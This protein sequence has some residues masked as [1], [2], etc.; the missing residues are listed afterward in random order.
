MERYKFNMCNR[1]K[2]EAVNQNST[3]LRPLPKNFNFGTLDL[4]EDEMIK[5]GLVFGSAE[6]TGVI[7]R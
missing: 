1:G 4:V 7:P 2:D 5:D 6:S 3:T